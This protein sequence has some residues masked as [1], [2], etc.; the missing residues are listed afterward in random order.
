MTAVD[1]HAAPDTDKPVQ[2][3]AFDYDGTI[4]NG[5]SGELLVHYMM[6]SMKVPVKT[7]LSVGWWAF[8]Y[9]LRLPI[10]QS[11]VRE[12]IFNLFTGDSVEDVNTFL[13]EFHDEFVKPLIRPEALQELNRARQDG[14]HVL[15]VS[16]SFDALLR[17]MISEIGADALLATQMECTPDGSRYT[18]KVKGRPV[19]GDE[20][21]RS[22][23]EYANE[24]YGE[25]KWELARAYGD[26]HSDIPLLAF[27]RESYAVTP[28]S[29]M[30]RTARRRQWTICQW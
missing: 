15:I 6:R 3:A 22:I 10:E 11:E 21:V 14:M 18:G 5:Q 24:L 1:T 28:D 27:A 7:V 4:I 30:E 23:T 2:L 19:E 17:P 9:K 12:D 25:G 20:K 16:A 13:G 26:H 29:K 8:R